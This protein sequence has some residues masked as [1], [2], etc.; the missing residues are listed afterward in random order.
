MTERQ[1][2]QEREKLSFKAKLEKL[3]RKEK[4]GNIKAERVKLKKARSQ[5]AECLKTNECLSECM[6]VNAIP[7][8]LMPQK[9]RGIIESIMEKLFLVVKKSTPLF[10]YQ[11]KQK[12]RGIR[13]E[14]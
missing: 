9:E 14:L 4:L 12:K 10:I 5:I 2:H 6:K 8:T 13:K 3:A 11:E 7:T 1:R